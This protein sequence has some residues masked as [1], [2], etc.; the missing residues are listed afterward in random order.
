MP[1]INKKSPAEK[2]KP[3]KLEADVFFGKN[4]KPWQR[5]LYRLAGIISFGLG[6]L[7]VVLPL[8]PTTP[9]LLLSVWCYARSSE[10]LYYW[11]IYHRIFGEFIR[12][13][14]DKKGIP[15]K[16]KIWVLTLLWGTIS[17]SAFVVVDLVWVK[18]LLMIIAIGVSIHILQ[19]PTL[20][21]AK[22]S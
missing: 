22:K 5:Y 21:K 15:L 3:E 6:M 11:L 12:N 7:G 1:D 20:K 8:L 18:I 9:F 13:Y 19:F 10:K 4:L 17:Y 16:I 14:R 2:I